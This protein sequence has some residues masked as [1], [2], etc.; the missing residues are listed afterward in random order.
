VLAP[1]E[2]AVLP[3]SG[4]EE[5]VRERCHRKDHRC[6]A[7]LACLAWKGSHPELEERQ[8]PQEPASMRGRSG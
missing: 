3:L 4:Q 6:L 1:S 5:E 2:Q 7:C 8:V